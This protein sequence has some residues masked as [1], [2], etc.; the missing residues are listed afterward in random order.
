[1]KGNLGFT[2]W[3]WWFWSW[4]SQRSFREQFNWRDSIHDVRASTAGGLVSHIV[5][6]FCCLLLC[7]TTVW[8]TLC[9]LLFKILCCVCLWCPILI[10][11]SPCHEERY[12]SCAL[13]LSCGLI[14]FWYFTQELE[15]QSPFR[16]YTFFIC[17]S[18]KSEASVSILFWHSLVLE[19][20]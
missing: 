2:F 15:V 9:D 4:W 11:I 1:M 17:W 7:S 20:E 6:W 12:L 18:H 8:W 14:Y 19:R 13:H 10:P 3:F 5:L 16:S